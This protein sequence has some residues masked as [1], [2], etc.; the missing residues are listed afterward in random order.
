MRP[1]R[2]RSDTRTFDEIM[3]AERAR[4]LWAL[5]KTN[6]GPHREELERRLQQIETALA[7][8]VFTGSSKD[9]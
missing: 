7:Q 3:N 5:Q 1:R 2:R 6:P 4:V 8:G 9:R